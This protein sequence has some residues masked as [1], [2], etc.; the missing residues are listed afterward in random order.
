MAKT[1]EEI[2]KNPAGVQAGGI[3]DIAGDL[4]EG[5]SAD[6]VVD[7]AGL[8]PI[9]SPEEAYEHKFPKVCGFIAGI[10]KLNPVQMGKDWYEPVMVRVV[11]TKA[12][13]GVIGKRGARQV[14]D[15]AADREILVPVT[16]G[17]EVSRPLMAAAR[18]PT[19]VYWGRFYIKGKMDTGQPSKMWVWAAELHKNTIARE[20]RYLLAAQDAATLAGGQANVRGALGQGEVVNQHGQI[21]NTHTGEVRDQQPRA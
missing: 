15:V 11:L 14:V 10:E 13:K 17:L 2:K 8:T 1:T 3:D 12:T 19:R 18:H 7:V 20:G 21:V 9:Y 5:W 6:D 16:G 4:P